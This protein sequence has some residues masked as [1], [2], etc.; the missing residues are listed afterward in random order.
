MNESSI[1]KKIIDDQQR[2]LRVHHETV[3]N[4][5]R[6]YFMYGTQ[7]CT[8][9]AWYRTGSTTTEHISSVVRSCKQTVPTSRILRLH[10]SL[11]ESV[12]MVYE[13]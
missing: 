9:M 12:P 5:R 8:E 6:N 4:K 1:S 3:T 11:I 13:S 7:P 2:I 10:G